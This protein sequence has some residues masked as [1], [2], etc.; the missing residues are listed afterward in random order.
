MS[1]E[2]R[3]REAFSGADEEPWPGARQ[4]AW[5][6]VAIFTVAPMF[7]FLDRGILT[8]YVFSN[9]AQPG[10]AMAPAAVVLES[11]AVFVFRYGLRA[12]GRRIESTAG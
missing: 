5:Y 8:L 11:L 2:T 4:A 10:Y 12:Y 3:G 6:A 1:E 9:E 7:N